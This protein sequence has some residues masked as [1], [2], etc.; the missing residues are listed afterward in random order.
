MVLRLPLTH[1]VAQGFVADGS[2]PDLLREL[3][4]EYES[5]LSQYTPK[6]LAQLRPGLPEKR[7]RDL[8]RTLELEAPDE[9]IVWWGWRNGTDPVH[10]LR[11]RPYPLETAVADYQQERL[12]DDP[13]D[14]GWLRGWL[15]VLGDSPWDS[16]AMDCNPSHDPPRIRYID[17]EVGGFDRFGEDIGRFQALSLCVPVTWWI[18]A[19]REGWWWTD[20]NGR[21]I[22]KWNILESPIPVEWSI[23]ELM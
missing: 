15:P 14:D 12:A 4:A 9:A 10:N 6:D 8:F 16:T 23:T 7:I 17:P 5:L 1:R 2:G 21:W 19:I 22:Q 18:T 20:A 11:T 3:L 13:T